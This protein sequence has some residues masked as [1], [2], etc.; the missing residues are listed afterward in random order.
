MVV[1]YGF[2]LQYG[3]KKVVVGF[4]VG[5]LW[6]RWISVMVSLWVS[7]WRERERERCV[8]KLILLGVI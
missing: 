2:L 3:F 8:N 1:F 6:C 7:R 4:A 5:L